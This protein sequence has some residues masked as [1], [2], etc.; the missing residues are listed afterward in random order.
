MTER[1]LKAAAVGIITYCS[2]CQTGQAP[3]LDEESQMVENAAFLDNNMFEAALEICSVANLDGLE[4]SYV[5][6]EE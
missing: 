1:E 5:G 4:L 6:E 2:L 3:E